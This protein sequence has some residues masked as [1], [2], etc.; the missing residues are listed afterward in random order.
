MTGTLTVHYRTPTPLHTALR[1]R[2]ASTASTAARSSRTGRI[3]PTAPVTAEAE[4]LFISVDAD[5]V[6]RAGRGFDRRVAEPD[7][8]A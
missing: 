6:P 7:G 5:Q 8:A 1:S 4:G 2:A 3:S